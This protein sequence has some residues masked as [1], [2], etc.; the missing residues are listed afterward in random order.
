M[1]NPQ[2][3]WVGER[4]PLLVDDELPMADRRRVERHLIGCLACQQHRTSIEQAVKALH[5]SAAFSPIQPDAP[6]LWPDLARQI[7]QSR[8]PAPSFWSWSWSRFEIWPA[9]GLCA[10][11]ALVAAV[12]IIGNNRSQVAEATARLP[13]K[14]RPIVAEAPV[15]A[16]ASPATSQPEQPAAEAAKPQEDAS[17]LPETVTATRMGYDLDHGTPMGTEPAP[18]A[19]EKKQPTY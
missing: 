10:S 14:T 17:A 8:R 9:V 6:S 1:A 3:K 16:Q 12:G 4:L 18:V 2:C 15:V 5:A 7:R 19:R 13:L 11:L